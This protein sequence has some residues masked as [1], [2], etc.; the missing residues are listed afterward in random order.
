MGLGKVMIEYFMK[1][2]S[3]LLYW[4][5]GLFLLSLSACGADSSEALS[6]SPYFNLK[7]FLEKQAMLLDSL[8]P[9]VKK[10]A[11]DEDP[12]MHKK[13]SKLDW[14]RELRLFSETSLHRSVYI[15][16]YKIDSLQE[17]KYKKVSY[18]AKSKTLPTRKMEI[19]YRQAGQPDSIRIFYQKKNWLYASERNA[20]LTFRL[21]TAQQAQLQHYRVKGFQSTMFGTRQDYEIVAEVS[22]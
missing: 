18:T 15:G 22:Q 1:L 20:L 12:P 6:D 11:L 4:F 13:T 8:Q 17:A 2:Y 5:F 7:V 19:Y 21:D 16:Q 9:M 10:I 3:P 14:T